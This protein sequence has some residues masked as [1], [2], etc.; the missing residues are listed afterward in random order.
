MPR[1]HSFLL[2]ALLQA[3]FMVA[4]PLACA[5]SFLPIPQRLILVLLQPGTIFQ[6][7]SKSSGSHMLA[8][9]GKGHSSQSLRGF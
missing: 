4:S 8:G 5:L 6:Q 2:L 3:I 1:F 9:L 7:L